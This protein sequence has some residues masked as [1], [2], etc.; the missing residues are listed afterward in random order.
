MNSI[1]LQFAIC[2]LRSASDPTG[3]MPAALFNRRSQIANRKSRSGFTLNELLIVCAIVVLIMALAVPAFN[4]LT[5][6]RSIEGAT[7]QVS[8]FLGQARAEAIGVQEI[9]GVLFFLDPGTERV[10]M[11][12]VRDSAFEGAAGVTYLDLVPD[13]DFINLPTGVGL[14]TVDSAAGSPRTDDGY[15]GYNVT[16]PTTLR[17]G[18][19]ILFDSSGKIISTRYGFRCSGDST[20]AAGS[21]MSLMGTLMTNGSVASINAGTGTDFVVPGIQLMS[22]VGFVLF[23]RATFVTAPTNGGNDTDI[24][25]SGGTYSTSELDEET[26]LDA[27][28]TLQLVNRYN[29][30]LIKAE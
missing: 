28:A 10:S 17:Y 27:N 6:S 1:H 8:A 13:R 30:T 5:G 29:G 11:A 7:N 22:Q 14:H 26:W 24:Q 20:A 18:G 4:V 21:P 3:V 19:V 23:D 9:R 16:A 2:D 12:M 15:I 25:I